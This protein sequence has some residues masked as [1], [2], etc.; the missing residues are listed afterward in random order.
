MGKSSLIARFC[1]NVFND[2][3]RETIGVSFKRKQVP[4]GDEVVDLQIWD[5]GGEEKYRDL[6]SNYVHGASGALVVFDLTRQETLDDVENWVEIIDANTT[7][8]VKILIGAKRDLKKQRVVSKKDIL[9]VNERFNFDHKP[10]ETSSKTGDNV[11]IAFS[12]ICEQIIE[13]KFQFC[14]D[15]GKGFSKT[16]KFCQYC[17]A[18]T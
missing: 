17:G 3:H 4:I 15:C 18:K 2:E 9:S 1:D 13:Q 11:E 16:L 6:L 7:N 8:L 14:K 5:F 12:S 10:L